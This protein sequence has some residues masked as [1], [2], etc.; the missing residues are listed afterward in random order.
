MINSWYYCKD[1][2]TSFFN[3]LFEDTNIVPIFYE[4][5]QNCGTHTNDDTYLETERVVTYL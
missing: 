1:I 5:S 2:C 4:Q 3:K